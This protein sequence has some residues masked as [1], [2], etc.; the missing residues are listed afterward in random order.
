ML[1]N[2]H[3]YSRFKC[4]TYKFDLLNFTLFLNFAWR[5]K[6]LLT[7]ICWISIEFWFCWKICTPLASGMLCIWGGVQTKRKRTILPAF[8][9]RSVNVVGFIV[10]LAFGMFELL[11]LCFFFY[12][13]D[14]WI[15]LYV[16]IGCYSEQRLRLVCLFCCHKKGNELR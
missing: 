2:W 1:K 13:T 14:A 3:F 8:T 10:W 15:H 7:S 12:F 16:C 5:S 9:V 11:P 6:F 4:Q